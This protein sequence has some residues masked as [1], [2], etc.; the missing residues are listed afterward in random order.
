M[1]ELSITTTNRKA[2]CV[3]CRKLIYA[4]EPRLKRHT[5]LYRTG[6]VLYC[7]NCAESILKSECKE[8]AK[9][10]IQLTKEVKKAS[11]IIV[12]NRLCQKT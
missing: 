10:K 11:K 3:K 4:N 12:L 7:H 6:Y 5:I 8:L 2:T 1:T 9:L